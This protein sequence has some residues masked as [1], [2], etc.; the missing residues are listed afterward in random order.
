[1]GTSTCSLYGS[2]THLL[3]YSPTKLKG[4]VKSILMRLYIEWRILPEYEPNSYKRTTAHLN[5]LANFFL[6][7]NNS[8]FQYYIRK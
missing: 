7:L 4:K 2:T 1:M 3:L 8:I 5:S 6:Q